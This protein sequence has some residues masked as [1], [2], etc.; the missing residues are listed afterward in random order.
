M[1]K[2]NFSIT[3]PSRIE[4]KQSLKKLRFKSLEGV[5]SHEISKNL[6]HICK[7]LNF[8]VILTFSKITM[9]LIP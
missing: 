2:A 4:K 6:V 7:I 5:K 3:L 8:T 1:S 9:N